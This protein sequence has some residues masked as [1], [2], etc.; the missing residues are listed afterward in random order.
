MRFNA[1]KARKLTD[2]RKKRTP[3]E[4][5]KPIRFLAKVSLKI[6]NRIMLLKI[7]RKIRHASRNKKN[8]IF[9][10]KLSPILREELEKNDNFLVTYHRYDEGFYIRW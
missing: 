8:Y 2:K 9:V 5:T 7:Y 10:Q 1:T 3:L 4:R 6:S